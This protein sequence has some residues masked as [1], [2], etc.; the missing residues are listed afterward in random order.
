MSAMSASAAT[1]I[2]IFMAAVAAA[3]TLAVWQML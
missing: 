1:P 3:L 2:E